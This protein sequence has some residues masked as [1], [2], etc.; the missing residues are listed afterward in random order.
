VLDID[1]CREQRQIG[2]MPK[3]KEPPLPPKEKFKRFVEVVREL[4]VDEIGVEFQPAFDKVAQARRGA[5]AK[6]SATRAKVGS[7]KRKSQKA[8]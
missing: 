4:E 8:E 6:K 7:P 3:R 1:D 5:K 2:T